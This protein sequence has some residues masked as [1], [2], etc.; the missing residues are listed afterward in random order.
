MSKNIEYHHS[1]GALNV[2]RQRVTGHVHVPGDDGYD[3]AC[4]VWSLCF[5]HE[6]AIVVVAATT[7]D[8]VEAVR[9]AHAADQRVAVQ[10]TGH[11]VSRPADAT[12]I[13]IITSLLTDVH[14]DAAARTATVAAGAKWGAVLAPAQEHGL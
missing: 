2:L 8:V 11:G 7:A 9:F 5:R 12:G 1:A 4:G 10:A 13:L 6:P 14:I 3:A